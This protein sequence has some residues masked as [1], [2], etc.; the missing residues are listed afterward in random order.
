MR[1]DIPP[2]DDPSAKGRSRSLRQPLG[3]ALGLL[4]VVTMLAVGSV[5]AGVPETLSR[6]GAHKHGLQTTINPPP[7]NPKQAIDHPAEGIPPGQVSVE[8]IA[9]QAVGVV[10]PDEF[11]DVIAIVNTELFS[12]K[13]PQMV[14][15]K[16]FEALRVIRVDR[17]A[18]GGHAG[19][20]TVAMS[21]CDAHYAPW[22][23]AN[24]ELK[25]TYVT[26][27]PYKSGTIDT[28]SC[29]TGDVSPAAVDARW[30]FSSSS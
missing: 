19:T 27:V 10:S 11:I 7:A 13:N 5:F 9:S 24:A 16:V 8:F 4:V 12:L 6:L 29:W 28:E 18:P 21:P 30:H 26:P 22:F 3:V 15:R 14:P 25:F 17:P 23:V 1:G 20:L 2:S